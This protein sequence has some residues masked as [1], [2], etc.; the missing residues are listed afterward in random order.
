MSVD[1]SKQALAQ[2]SSGKDFSLSQVSRTRRV[3]RM[4]LRTSG[5][6]FIIDVDLTEK[7]V[8][9]H[10]PALSEVAEA[11]S[12]EIMAAKAKARE[13]L[14][15]D[16]GLDRI[17]VCMESGCQHFVWSGVHGPRCGMTPCTDCQAKNYLD[18]AWSCPLP[19]PKFK[20]ITVNGTNIN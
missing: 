4:C 15:Q 5:M 8:V 7:T 10:N 9:F 19:S 11:S 12:R 16:L 2:F 13:V 17:T 14:A 6:P 1:I 20:A 3:A 18:P